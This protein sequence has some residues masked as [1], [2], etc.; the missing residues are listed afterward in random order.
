MNNSSEGGNNLL[1][2]LRAA[3][4]RAVAEQREL[5][6]R[7]EIQDRADA[8]RILAALPAIAMS[9]AEGGR[10]EVSLME[11]SYEGKPHWVSGNGFTVFPH[12]LVGPSRFVYEQCLDQGFQP[13]LRCYW[14]R[15]R[16]RVSRIVCQLVIQW[17]EGAD[18]MP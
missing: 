9:A 16:K 11:V 18:S 6:Q 3:S 10:F 4:L 15:V 5:Q 12:Q 1:Q 7:Q 2:Q 13:Q 17:G 14:Q 8:D